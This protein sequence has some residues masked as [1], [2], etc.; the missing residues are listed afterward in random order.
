[1]NQA[2]DVRSRYAHGAE[3]KPVDLAALRSLTRRI[4][5][6]WTAL[7]AEYSDARTL[8]AVL[9]DALLSARVL[10]YS[11]RQ[12]LARFWEQVMPER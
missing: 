8:L 3:P 7:A 4:M 12:P 1:M 6:T 10:E 5:V 2:Y 9:D 11:V